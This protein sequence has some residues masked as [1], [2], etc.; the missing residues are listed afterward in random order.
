[1][2]HTI[3][4]FFSFFKS[5]ELNELYASISIRAFSLSLI[6]VFVPI[7]FYLIG[8]PLISIFFF[9]IL[10]SLFH[11][12]FSIPVAKIS[13]RFGIK[14]S[15]LFSIPSLI[16]F[17]FLLYSIEIFSWPLA[18]LAVFSGLSTSMFWI[19][20]H[21]E[22]AK[23]SDRKNRGKEIGF[24]GIIACLFSALG[25]VL[26]GIFLTIFGFKILFI[27]V[28]ALLFLS[29]IPLFFSKEVHE[30]VPLSLSGFFKGQKTTDILSFLGHGIENKLGTIVWPLF[31]FIFIL[32]ENYTSLGTVAGLTIGVAFVSMIFI[33]K[34]SDLYRKTVLKIGSVSN[35]V[36]W[37]AKS[38]IV[39][40]IQVFVV[41]AFYG[42][43]QTAMHI[44]FDAITYDKVKKNNLVRIILEREIYHH[45]GVLILF[46][47]LI[48]F[49][50]S[51]TEIFRYAGSISSLMRFFF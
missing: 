11:I 24:S 14:H 30:P 1:M 16:I 7:Y 35:A 4:N 45:I 6:G 34:F 38:F 15:I 19:P 50:E 40:P 10:H 25:P 47:L 39:T 32:G 18:L 22:F 42:I 33:S 41:G 36:I 23:F 43:S 29:V 37:V 27:V 21:I 31:I 9:Y 44:S 46:L 12:V 51:L 13:S 17:F 26:G 2:I 3:G 5:R 20:Y 49:T 28:S 48:L 8:Y